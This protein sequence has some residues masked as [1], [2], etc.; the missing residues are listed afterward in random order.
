MNYLKSP[1]KELLDL[2]EK[3]N[4]I[5]L[6]MQKADLIKERLIRD[7]STSSNSNILSYSDFLILVI[8]MD[9]I[10]DYIS[11]FFN[12]LNYIQ[13]NSLNIGF[14]KKYYRLIRNTLEMAEILKET[15][16]LIKNNPKAIIADINRMHR[17]R[18]NSKKLIRNCRNFLFNEND[19]EKRNLVI[20]LSS[21]NILET[22][23][24]KM[25][26]VIEIIRILRYEN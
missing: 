25:N 26:H 2:E 17:I 8:R 12:N 11:E 18:D 9:G 15:I 22:L 24:D 5:H 21:I 20:T 23:I 19:L 3:K 14:K 13:F 16:R 6:D 4:K 7:F 1:E 10:L